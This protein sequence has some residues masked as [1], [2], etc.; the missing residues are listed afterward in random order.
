MTIN[1]VS[2][3]YLGA[4]MLPVIAQV[5]TQLGQLEVESGTGQYADLGA[6]LGGSSGYELSLRGTSDLLQSLTTANSLTAGKL[7]TTSDA[8]TSIVSAARSTLST[9]VAWQPGAAGSDLTSTGGSSMQGL[10]GFANSAYDNQY[11]FG[12]IN[13]SVAPMAAYSSSTANQTALVSAFQTQFGFPPTDPQAQNLT[14]TQITGFLN[15]AF[16]SQFSGSNWTTNWSSASSTDETTQISP[17]QTVET[18]TNLNSGGF[19]PLAQ[20]Y[21]MI[22]LFGGSELSQTAQQAVVTSATTL[23]NQGLSQLTATGSNIGQMQSQV[24]QADDDMSTQTTLLGSQIGGLDNIDPAKVAT[25]LSFLTTQLETAYQVTAQL[26][27][28]SLAQYLPT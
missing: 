20:A 2:S 11:V 21:A 15:G 27:K 25:Q 9:L 10:I 7:S 5:D 4:A 12:G 17:G 18:S 13:S 16:A 8:L 6:H 1:A 28:L 23:V 22:S 26:Q 24:K 3:S 14:S 19:Q